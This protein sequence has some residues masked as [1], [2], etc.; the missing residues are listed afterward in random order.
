MKKTFFSFLAAALIT[1]SFL[2]AEE[3]QL[4]FT[5]GSNLGKV[6]FEINNSKKNIN[7]FSGIKINKWMMSP[8]FSSFVAG[9]DSN[10]FSDKKI[11]RELIYIR[12][13]YKF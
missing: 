13:N 4:N 3:S 7:K 5:F 8:N 11:S 6:P 12:F 1:S 9:S 2:L 10:N